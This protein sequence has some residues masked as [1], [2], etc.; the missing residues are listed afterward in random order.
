[1]SSVSDLYLL[2][3]LD[4]ALDQATARLEEIERLLEETEEL[5]LARQVKEESDLAVDELRSRQKD[6]DWQVEEVRTKV[7]SVDTKLYGGSVRNPKELSDLDADLRSLKALLAHREDG[8]LGLMVDIDEAEVKRSAATDAYTRI[9]AAW[10]AAC[11]ALLE[12]RSSVEP[13]ADSLRQ[14]RLERTDALDRSSLSLYTLLR[15]RKSGLAVAGVEQ[16]MC[17]GCRITLPAAV[18]QRAKAGVG[19]VQ[20][21]SCER[22]LF[23]N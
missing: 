3:E 16:G 8:L 2:Q 14:R 1:M 17:Q 11:K 5:I 13:D 15:E 21:V 7:A 18:V 12:E 23:V 22:I 6:I 9:E 20:C 10:S 19:P 4:S